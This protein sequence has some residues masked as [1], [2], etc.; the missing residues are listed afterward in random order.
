MKKMM[1]IVFVVVGLLV[2]GGGAAGYFMMTASPAGAEPETVEHT[3]PA[4]LV[5]METFL[6]NISQGADERFAK[7]QLRLTV[8]PDSLA[9]KM[10][11]DPLIQAKMRDRV[12]TLLASKSYEEVSTPIGKESFRREIKTVLEPLVEDG[13]IRE[14][15][16]QEFV[17]Q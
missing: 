17:V 12:L 14:V 9:T 10:T 2:G 15:L 5:S 4:G 7:L 3:G 16:F 8:V 13:E 11:E 6:V 1:P